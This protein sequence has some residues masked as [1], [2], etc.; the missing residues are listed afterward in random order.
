MCLVCKS[1]ASRNCMIAG[2]RARVATA[3]GFK[4]KCPMFLAYKRSA[5]RN[6]HIACDRARIAT[7]LGLTEKAHVFRV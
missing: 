7:D 5:S 3:F 4:A 6:C 1:S 2:D